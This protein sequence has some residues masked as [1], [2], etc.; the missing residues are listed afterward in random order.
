MLYFV[1][2]MGLVVALGSYAIYDCLV[3]FDEEEEWQMEVDARWDQMMK[4]N[5]RLFDESVEC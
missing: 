3:N 4:E 5:R 2:L 1:L